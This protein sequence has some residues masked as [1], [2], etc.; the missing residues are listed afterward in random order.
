MQMATPI[1]GRWTRFA[2]RAIGAAIRG[3]RCSHGHLMSTAVGI[4]Q[5]PFDLEES[6]GDTV[7]LDMDL[8]QAG[9]GVPALYLKS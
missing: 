2:Q 5:P 7:V 3:I 8:N 4:G 9:P 6:S 1:V